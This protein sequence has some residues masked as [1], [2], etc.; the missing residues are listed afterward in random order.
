MGEERKR[1]QKYKNIPKEKLMELIRKKNMKSEID[2]EYNSIRKVL[3]SKLNLEERRK[4]REKGY[5]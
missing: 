5:Y 4:F 1:Q 3:I 2:E